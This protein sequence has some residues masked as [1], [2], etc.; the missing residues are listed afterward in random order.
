M[1]KKCYCGGILNKFT[2][3][4][5]REIYICNYCKLKYDYTSYINTEFKDTN[6][7]QLLNLE[8]I[9][10]IDNLNDQISKDVKFIDELCNFIKRHDVTISFDN[11][12]VLDVGCSNGLKSH[13]FIKNN[14]DYYA[15]DLNSDLFNLYNKLL[16]SKFIN[17]ENLKTHK[18]DFIFCW[19]TLEHFKDVNDFKKIINE[20]S[21]SN[22]I[23]LLQIP[24]LD[25]NHLFDC[26]YLFFDEISLNHLFESLNYEKI[27][28]YE[29]KKNNFMTYI[30]KCKQNN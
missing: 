4:K 30:G 23:M 14:F 21:K 16:T 19:H 17:L 29:D 3:I 10:V 8:K 1:N 24:L 15:T 20:V 6:E 9:Y 22:T 2:N 25:L 7:I 13:G 18:F 12:T 5:S 26:H 11:K 28:I 27:V